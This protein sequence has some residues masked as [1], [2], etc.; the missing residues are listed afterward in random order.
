MFSTHRKHHYQNINNKCLIINYNLKLS[1]MKTKIIT[2]IAFCAFLSLGSI[3]AQLIWQENFTQNVGPLIPSP[4]VSS[5][6]SA[7]NNPLNLSGWKTQS[8]TSGATDCFD[9]VSPGLIYN[10]YSCSGIG[11]ALKFNPVSGQSIYKQW[12]KTIKNDSSVYVSFMIN[13]PNAPATGGDFFFGLR[14]DST[15][16]NTNW[17]SCIY[18]SVD[19]TFKGQ[20]VS[21]SIKKSSSGTAVPSSIYFPSNT[22]LFVVLNYHI[23]KLNGISQVAET[24]LYDDKMSVYI[25]PSPTDVEPVTPTIY[26]ADAAQ[27][28]L[29]RWGATTIIGGA[30]AVYLRSSTATPGNTPAYTIDGIRVGYTWADVMSAS[31]GLKKTTADNFRYVID[32]NK[33]LTINA[34]PSNYSVYSLVS[35]SGQ[36]LFKG[37][38]S[39]E[40][41]KINVSTLKSGIYI[42][43]LNGKQHA[44]AKIVIR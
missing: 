22:T 31:D 27:K 43:N 30:K 29:Y 17:G 18:A 28:D 33:Q 6:N 2:L 36:Q 24:G 1:I 4:L 38:I 5:D 19:T 14:M 12:S 9:V 41:N 26:C 25:N 39:S 3:Q 16:T 34:S 40:V 13:F 42:L 11:N 7:I 20:E 37:S 23:G 44:T 10:G 15:A 8:N 21:L 35:V 32:R